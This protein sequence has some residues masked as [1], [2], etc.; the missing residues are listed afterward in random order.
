MNSNTRFKV[1]F[2]SSWFPNKLE[3]TNGNFVQRHAEAVS[4]LHDVEI[5]HAIGDSTQNEKFIFDD[6][7]I[8]GIRTLIVYYK[9]SNNPLLNFYRRMKAYQ[10]GF[11]RVEKPDL[12]HGNVLHNN[13][14][15]AVYLKE[16]YKIPFVI[17]EHWTALREINRVKL[18]FVQKII[19]KY[20]GNNAVFLLPVSEDLRKSL[21]SLPINVKMKVVPNVVDNEL[22]RVNDFA[23]NEFTFIH[24]SSL[25]SRKNPKKIIEAAINLWKKGYDFNLKIGGDGDVN[26]LFK[27]I[28]NSL[29]RD[30]I[31]IFGEQSMKEVAIKLSNA[32]CFI[33][34]SDDENQPCVIAESFSCGIKVISTNVGGVSEFFPSNFGILLNKVDLDLLEDAMIRILNNEIK[35]SKFE[36]SNYAKQIFSKQK[37]AEQ[38]SEIYNKV[39]TK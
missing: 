23:N 38:F 12:V 14:L 8:N 1:L 26:Q 15:F 33:L 5:L 31:E 34:L 11:K 7:V 20:I 10:L 32:D 18:P 24:I 6:K 28:E 36:I 17:T 35:S 22:F 39:L 19:A 25:I 13:M 3:P 30:R 9:N 29:F 4:L 16:K 37:I 27:Q 2:I 21:N